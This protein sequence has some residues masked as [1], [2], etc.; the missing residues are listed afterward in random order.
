ME[1]NFGFVALLGMGGS[2]SQ[3]IVEEQLA[4]FDPEMIWLQVIEP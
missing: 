3:T 4:T 2:N 1:S